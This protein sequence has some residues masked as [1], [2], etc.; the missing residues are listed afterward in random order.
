M[1]LVFYL[2]LFLDSIQDTILTFHHRVSLVLLAVTV[3]QTYLVFD[4]HDSFEEY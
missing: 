4:D 1:A 2:F 3:S